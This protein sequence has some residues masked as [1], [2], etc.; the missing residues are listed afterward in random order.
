[1]KEYKE[2]AR[3]EMQELQRQINNE[4]DE[5]M[6]KYFQIMELKSIRNDKIDDLL[7]ETKKIEFGLR[8]KKLHLITKRAQ[9]ASGMSRLQIPQSPSGSGS[10]RRGGILEPRSPASARKL[11]KGGLKKEPSSA[12]LRKRRD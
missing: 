7:R 1:M 10:R 9:E 8:S 5:N 3:N 11:K 6:L 2:K 12:T 4:K